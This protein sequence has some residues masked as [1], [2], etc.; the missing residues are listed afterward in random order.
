M[1]YLAKIY[2]DSDLDEA[3]DWIEQALDVNLN[4]AEACYVRGA[5]MGRQ[6]S[7]SIFSALSY[8]EKSVNSF[9]KAVEL[10]PDSIKYRKGSMQFHTS[11]PSIAGGDLDIAKVQIEKLRQLDPK[12]GLE[13]EIN[14]ELSQ[15]NDALADTLLQ[16]AKQTYNDIPDFFFQAGMLQQRKENY[17]A[18]FEEFTR[19]ISKNA[20]TKESVVAKYNAL[21]QLGRT[22]VLDETNIDAGIMA[23]KQYL[24]EAPDLDGLSPKPWAEFRLAN[25]MVF[26]AQKLEVKLIYLRLAK[27]DNKELAKKAKKAAKKI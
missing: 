16:Q 23:L 17:R 26:N 22:S 10:Q 27:V 18:A 5:I 15:D 19:A 24:S 13:A 21:Y 6:A 25:L 7:G 3:E 9:T 4:N 12:A 8:A 14:Y 1:L 20:D 11:A 2:M